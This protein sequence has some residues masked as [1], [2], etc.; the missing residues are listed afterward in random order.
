VH[1]LEHEVASASINHDDGA[2]AVNGCFLEVI[3]IKIV[4]LEGPAPILVLD[5][6]V[7]PTCDLY[8]IIK[9]TEVTET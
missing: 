8:A 3:Q 4:F 6:I 1:G 5:W 9:I 2:M 7:H